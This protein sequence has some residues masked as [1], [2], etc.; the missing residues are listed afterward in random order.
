[1]TEPLLESKYDVVIVGGG[2]FGLLIATHCARA[3]RSVLLVEKEAQPMSRAS[4]HNQA[5]VHNGYHY[6]RSVLTALRSRINFPR[7]TEDYADCIHS[8][9]TKVYAVARRLSKVSANQ[10][11]RFIER[12][13]APVEPAPGAL[14][15]LFDPDRIEATFRCQEYAFDA[16]KLRVIAMRR[17]EEAGV[18][19][20]FSTEATSAC[21][22]KSGL[23]LG[24]SSSEPERK[25]GARI[26]FNCTYSRINQLLRASCLEPVRLRH[27]FAEMCLVEPPAELAKVGVTVMCGSFFSIMPFPAQ[28]LHSLSHVR[29]TPRYTWMDTSDSAPDPYQVPGRHPVSTAFAAMRADSCR[30]L[31]VMQDCAYRRSLWEIK[32]VLPKSEGDDSRPILFRACPEN[33][34]IINVMGGKIDNI[35]DALAEV[36]QVLSQLS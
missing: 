13:G 6:P 12:I 17:A 28:R 2:F 20:L 10:F 5:R 35:Y 29:Y 30:Y 3:G 36:D 15:R 24:L 1:M 32:T 19:L 8:D 11:T 23:A 22:G 27:E 9:F 26:I 14:A 16:D 31:P 25:V 7:F 33:P 18:S 21:V 34:N 4:Y